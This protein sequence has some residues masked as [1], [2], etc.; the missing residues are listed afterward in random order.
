MTRGEQIIRPDFAK[1]EIVKKIKTI[2]AQLY[3]EVVAESIKKYDTRNSNLSKE[4]YDSMVEKGEEVFRC[5]KEAL[6]HLETS[7]MYA[8]KALT[9]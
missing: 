6:N 2:Y 5:A 8:V 7:A 1:D 3:D 9:A 4:D